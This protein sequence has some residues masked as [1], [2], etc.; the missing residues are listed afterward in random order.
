MR[1]PTFL[2]ATAAS[3]GVGLSCWAAYSGVQWFR[4]GKPKAEAEGDPLLDSFMPEYEAIDRHSVVVNTPAE[5]AFEAASEID[6]QQSSMVRGIFRSRE[7]MLGSRQHK[8]E[9]PSKP[10]LEW[11]EELGWRRLA[12]VPER[13]VIFGSV[14]Q[15]WRADVVFRSVA[16]DRF[17]IFD[18]PGYVKVVWSLRAD[19]V[20]AEK[21][22]LAT[23]T[24]VMATSSDA[25]LRFRAYWSAL[26]P[27]IVLIR[28]IALRM[29]KRAAERMLAV[30]GYST[31]TRVPL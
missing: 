6:I 31:T 10:L 24:R 28:F 8:E 20:S 1:R 11:A 18:Q 26:Q 2:E 14:V 21:C 29:A 23:E 16:P 30:E 27:G 17:R 4:Y 3:V 7:W 25:R 5:V 15:P 12:E 22:R 19:S 9:I 13:E